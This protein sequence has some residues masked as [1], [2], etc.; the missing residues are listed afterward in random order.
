MRLL[1]WNTAW[2]SPR[3]PKGTYIKEYAKFSN[4]DIIC[5]TEVRLGLEPESGYFIESL[6]DYGYSK[7]EGKRKVS[8][9]SSSQ[10]EQ[11]DQ[12]GSEELPS[13]RFISG[14]SKG[15]RFVAVCIPWKDAHVNSGRKDR[16]SWEDHIS[17]IEGLKKIIEVYKKESY[18]ICI[19]G[20]YNQRIPRNRQPEHVY[21]YLMDLLSSGFETKTSDTLDPDGKLLIDHISVSDGLSVDIEDIHPKTTKDGLTLSD[22]VGI[23]ANLTKCD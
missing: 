1:L 9:W 22:H 8:L 21:N 12:V 17:Y 19:L 15:I 7:T 18:P 3:F 11:V 20:D 10:W 5:Y 6:P 14:I 13:G 4:L 23:I 16:K 2:A